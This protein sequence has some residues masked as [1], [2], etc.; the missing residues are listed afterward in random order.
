MSS[1]R[2]QQPNT[3]PNNA[4]Q[5]ISAHKTPPSTKYHSYIILRKYQ[6]TRYAYHMEPPPPRALSPFPASQHQTHPNPISHLSQGRAALALF[7]RRR[8]LRHRSPRR[9]SGGRTTRSGH[10]SGGAAAPALP[11]RPLLPRVLRG[12]RAPA[13]LLPPAAAAPPVALGIGAALEARAV[14]RTC[15]HLFPSSRRGGRYRRR[16]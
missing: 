2:C 14:R 9:C 16:C 12:L 7:F 1:F 4:Q 6:Y 10:H 11:R 8:R 13:A 5:R 15:E 3:Q